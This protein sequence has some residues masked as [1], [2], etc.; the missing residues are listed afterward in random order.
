M[1]DLCRALI[2]REKWSTVARLIKGIE[3][4]PESTRRAILGYFTAVLLGGKGDA[5][6]VMDCFADNYFDT[7]RAGLVM[8]CYQAIELEG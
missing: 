7:G 6:A 8:S 3:Q 1:I 4:E 2:K 5:W